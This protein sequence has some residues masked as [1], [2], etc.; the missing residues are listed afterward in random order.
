MTESGRPV[1]VV[2]L[3]EH[4]FTQ[5]L[6]APAYFMSQQEYLFGVMWQR[7][8]ASPLDVRMHYGRV[9][10]RARCVRG[11]GRRRRRDRCS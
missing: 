4:I 8:M 1:V 5:V 10:S 11:R 9:F 6:S 3:R 2:G 7:I